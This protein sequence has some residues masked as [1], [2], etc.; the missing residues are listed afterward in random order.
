MRLF[1]YKLFEHFKDFKEKDFDLLMKRCKT[2]I[3]YGIL[4]AKDKFRK[5]K[6]DF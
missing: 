6:G 4:S 3:T 5:R 2:A 1:K